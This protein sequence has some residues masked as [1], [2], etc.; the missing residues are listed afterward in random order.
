MKVG[1]GPKLLGLVLGDKMGKP[2]SIDSEGEGAAREV[3]QAMAG[4]RL[5]NALCWLDA[6]IIALDAG[7]VRRIFPSQFHPP[8]T[9][10]HFSGSGWLGEEM[11][12]ASTALSSLTRKKRHLFG[13]VA[14]RVLAERR[15]DM[16]PV[17]GNIED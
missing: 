3:V 5:A 1:A 4:A 14:R 13:N 17:P 6:E 9:G 15:Q 7:K 12:A 16:D 11:T 8:G 10:Y 2:D